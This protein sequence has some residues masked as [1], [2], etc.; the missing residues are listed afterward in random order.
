M[1]SFLQNLINNFLKLQQISSYVDFDLV[2]FSLQ[3]L[4]NNLKF[5][6]FTPKFTHMV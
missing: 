2:S 1:V 4:I 6:L 3:R 5:H